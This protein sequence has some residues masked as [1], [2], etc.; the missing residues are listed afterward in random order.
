ML[1]F[2]PESA[3]SY[4]INSLDSIS[5]SPS[6]SSSS[7]PVLLSSFTPIIGY[8]LSFYSEK[9]LALSVIMTAIFAL[10]IGFLVGF[11]V[12][13]KYQGALFAAEGGN[14]SRTGSIYISNSDLFDDGGMKK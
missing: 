5:S 10:S 11:C 4:S 8:T 9:T 3:D 12:S 2:I 1:F 7:S 13:R 6:S 14:S